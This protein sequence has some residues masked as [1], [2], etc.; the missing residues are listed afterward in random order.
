MK[1]VLRITTSILGEGSVSSL[2]MD[3]LLVKLS[4]QEQ[5]KITERNFA[6]QAIP[7]LDGEWLQAI[8]AAPNE[9]DPTQTEKSAFSDQLIAEL[10]EADIILIAL[11]MYNF[12]LPSMLKAWVDH[13][14]RAGVTFT[15]SETGPVGLLEGKQAY[16]VMA[17]GGLHEPGVTDFLRPYMK[18]VMSFVG[19]SDVEF[20]TAD[21][22]NMGPER[23]EQGLAQARAE[24]ENLKNKIDEHSV[25]QLEEE[26]AA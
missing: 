12:S 11:P 8:S 7:H 22:L 15:Y 25:G 3:E 26:A 23:K 10:Q 1:N 21:G 17:M 16:L 4:A 18:Q 5:F 14:A 9:R 2:L 24:I 19:I 6:H 13:I 20:I